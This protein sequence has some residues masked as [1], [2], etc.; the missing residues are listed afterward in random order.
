MIIVQT[1]TIKTTL[2]I[3]A[4]SVFSYASNVL[5]SITINVYPVYLDSTFCRE[6]VMIFVLQGTGKTQ[7]NINVRSATILALSVLVRVIQNVLNALL[8][9]L[10][11]FIKDNVWKSVLVTISRTTIL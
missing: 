8:A 3:N 9:N 4:R 2:Q 6:S 1:I 11:L 5:V 10:P 7:A